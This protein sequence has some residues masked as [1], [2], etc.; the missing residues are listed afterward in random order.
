MHIILLY[1]TPQKLVSSKSNA[2]S[3]WTFFV[4]DVFLSPASCGETQLERVDDES[5]SQQTKV[6]STFLF[7][8]KST[9]NFKCGKKGLEGILA[10]GEMG[11]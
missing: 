1:I 3:L 6:V 7:S 2:F 5:P 10:M 8:Q 11:R 9:N 4:R